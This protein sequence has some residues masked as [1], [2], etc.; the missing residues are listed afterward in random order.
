MEHDELASLDA[1]LRLSE[2]MLAAAHANEWSRVAALQADC[3][4]LLRTKFPATEAARER[5]FAV[6]QAYET[7]RSLTG[8]AREQTATQLAHHQQS[9]RAVSAYLHSSD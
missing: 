5:L 9:H 2:H 3:D 7:L 6:Q 1:A 4:A 8:A